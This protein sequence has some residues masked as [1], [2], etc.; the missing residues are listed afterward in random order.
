MENIEDERP[1]KEP[2]RNYVI[3]TLISVVIFFALYF[4]LKGVKS[5][6]FKDY[7]KY[8]RLGELAAESRAAA[9]DTAMDFTKISK[10]PEYAEIKREQGR[11]TV[12]F[13]YYDVGDAEEFIGANADLRLSDP[14]YDVK[15]EICNENGT[16]ENVIADSYV[17]IDNPNETL[18]IYELNGVVCAQYRSN[19]I[20]ADIAAI[21]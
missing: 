21:F 2:K 11:V 13:G 6:I 19:R 5:V 15:E 16:I 9:Y 17:N 8:V 4:G 10:E 20:T 12:I 3:Y 1:N 18:I 7:S 14:E